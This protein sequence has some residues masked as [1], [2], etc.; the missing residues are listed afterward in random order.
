M[1]KFW[2]KEATQ[3]A[4]FICN[5]LVPKWPQCQWSSVPIRTH[6]YPYAYRLQT[7]SVRLLLIKSSSLP[8][9]RKYIP[10]VKLSGCLWVG[11]DCVGRPG[12]MRRYISAQAH[13]HS[14]L[15]HI[16][17]PHCSQAGAFSCLQL[18]PSGDVSFPLEY[19]FISPGPFHQDDPHP[20][21]GRCYNFL[22]V[23]L[24]HS[25]GKV[26]TSAVACQLWMTLGSWYS[27]VG[28]VATA[29]CAPHT[30][31]GFP[32]PGAA[33]LFIHSL[34]PK[35]P[36]TGLPAVHRCSGQDSGILGAVQCSF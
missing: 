16:G 26:S 8:V 35:E 31:S 10:P 21:P 17:A 9:K 6:T 11:R 20:F 28:L 12:H 19:I 18:I 2:F 27:Y 34:L 4:I 22:D 1:I 33:Q 25:S 30:T 32:K 14:C 24:T 36:Q 15:K 29:G 13:D 23:I 3:G 7:F 5:S